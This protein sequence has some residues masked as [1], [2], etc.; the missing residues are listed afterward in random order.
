MMLPLL[1]A[2]AFADAPEYLLADLGVQLDLPRSTW[3]MTRWSDYDFAGKSLDESMHIQVWS[4]PVQVEIADP[5]DGWASLYLEKAEGLGA[6]DAKLQSAKR[7]AWAGRA[8]AAVDVGFT[9]GSGGSGV[10]YGASTAVA[11]QT[12]HVLVAGPAARAGAIGA[13]RE[14]ILTTLQVYKPPRPVEWSATLRGPGMSTVLPE[15]FRAPLDSEKDAVAERAAEVGMDDLSGCLVAM[16]PQAGRAPDAL[17]T[18]PGKGALGVV[19]E[20]SFAGVEALVRKLTWG[21]LEVEAA[22]PLSLTDRMAFVYAPD[23][24]KVGLAVGVVPAASGVTRTWVVGDKADETLGAAL[25]AALRASTWD[26]PHP[27]TGGETVA[28]FVNYRP[29]HP[30][31]LGG[32]CCA[33]AVSGGAIGAIAFVVMRPKRRR[34]DDDPDGG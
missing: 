3:H 23:P 17:L 21:P 19:D 24:A 1:A 22:T 6:K 29:T 31:V 5:V 27:V 16:R 14:R 32:A 33:L 2:V 9:F 28:Y 4:T 15:G 11:D 7:H 12:L 20:F 18:C 25:E 26:G 10:L 8:V 34:H 13:Q 30:A